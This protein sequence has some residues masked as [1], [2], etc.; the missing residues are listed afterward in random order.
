MCSSGHV[1]ATLCTTERSIRSDQIAP[2]T[3]LNLLANGLIVQQVSAMR[4]GRSLYG[5][6]VDF[7]IYFLLR[8]L[9]IQ[10]PT[11]NSSPSSVAT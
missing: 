1:F 10:V 7:F 11:N 4:T 8:F 6:F 2:F 3:I 9:L 5:P